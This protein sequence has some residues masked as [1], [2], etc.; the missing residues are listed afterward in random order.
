MG[1]V[2]GSGHSGSEAEQ[3]GGE[4]HG[5]MFGL[6]FVALRCVALR[7][8]GVERRSCQ[9]AWAID[10]S[11]RI[12]VEWYG[13]E[14]DCKAQFR[15]RPVSKKWQSRR[16]AGVLSPVKP[17]ER[18][19]KP[20]SQMQ[21]QSVNN[22]RTIILLRSTLDSIALLNKHALLSRTVGVK[23]L[24]Q[25]IAPYF[26]LFQNPALLV[27]QMLSPRP[28]VV[29]ICLPISLLFSMRPFVARMLP[30]GSGAHTISYR[31]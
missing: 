22:T 26:F 17:A 29:Q 20:R 21:T 6:R 1:A 11:E 15:S 9:R 12:G 27:H 13:E 8:A 14:E 24:P 28:H 16:V 4:L 31:L 5:D 30:S 3:D 18:F 2:E 23:I 7:C 25:A 10:I 19:G